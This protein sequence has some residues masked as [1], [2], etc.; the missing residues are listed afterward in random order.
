MLTEVERFLAHWLVDH[1]WLVGTLRD[2]ADFDSLILGAVYLAGIGWLIRVVSLPLRGWD[3]HQLRV[4]RLT[5]GIVRLS[6][7]I[8]L[9]MVST[10][11]AVAR[12]A[13]RSHYRW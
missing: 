3:S 4:G 11:L 9:V 8:V 13:G 10:L 7:T 6:V 12:A 2:G 1:G 5:M